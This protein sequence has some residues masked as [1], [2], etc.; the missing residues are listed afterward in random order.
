MLVC[1]AGTIT[2]ILQVGTP[3]LWEVPQATQWAQHTHHQDS[4]LLATWQLPA[5]CPDQRLLREVRTKPN[6]RLPLG[7]FLKVETVTFFSFNT[8]PFILD[9]IFS[10][11]SI[12]TIS[13][14]FPQPLQYLSFSPRPDPAQHIPTYPDSTN[15][16][17]PSITLSSRTPVCPRLPSSTSAQ[18]THPQKCSVLSSSQWTCPSPMAPSNWS[19]HNTPVTGCHISLCSHAVWHQEPCLHHVGSLGKEQ[20]AYSR[21]HCVLY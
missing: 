16:Y 6:K 7:N 11:N 19:S 4:G 2:H 3:T 1:R 21:H 12:R 9:P 18:I 20:Y 17:S 5:I 15:L 10:S 13:L 14:F 8:P